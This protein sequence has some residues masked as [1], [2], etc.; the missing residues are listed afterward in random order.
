MPPALG[1]KQLSCP[2]P[3]MIVGDIADGGGCEPGLDPAPLYVLL[4]ETLLL[5][6]S[7]VASEMLVLRSP[8]TSWL[9]PLV[10]N[11]IQID[12]AITDI[13]A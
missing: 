11:P 10:G 13:R 2:P 4:S 7:T 1:I 12:I 6:L 8:V 5:L 3:P 9:I